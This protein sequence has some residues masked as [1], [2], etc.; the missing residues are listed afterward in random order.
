M[1]DD[2]RAENIRQAQENLARAHRGLDR[3]YKA[4]L[5]VYGCFGAVLLVLVV[6]AL[7]VTLML[8]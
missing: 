6:A 2:E 7:A 4:E 5:G 8:F 1:T 3:T